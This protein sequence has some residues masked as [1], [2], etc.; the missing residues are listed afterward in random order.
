[1]NKKM[2]VVLTSF[3]KDCA[4]AL[5]G[6]HQSVEET[7][8]RRTV[9]P[10]RLAALEHQLTVH[11]QA[12]SDVA[13]QSN[14]TVRTGQRDANRQFDVAVL[15]AMASAYKYCVEERGMY[16]VLPFLSLPLPLPLLLGLILLVLVC[17]P[18]ST[19]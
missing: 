3:A 12:F 17:Q 8:R 7:G 15:A 14:A 9:D 18:S 16:S 4:L 11:E 5:C 2:P 6:F 1:M 10:A 13:V 19:R